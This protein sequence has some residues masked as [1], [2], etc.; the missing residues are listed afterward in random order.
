MSIVLGLTVSVDVALPTSL[1]L[2]MGTSR[3]RTRHHRETPGWPTVHRAPT[4][5][6]DAGGAEAAGVRRNAP[7]RCPPAEGPPRGLGPTVLLPGG[8]RQRGVVCGMVRR[9]EVRSGRA[10]GE[11][12][13]SAWAAVRAP[14]NTS[15]RPCDDTRG[16]TS[17]FAQRRRCGRSGWTGGKQPLRPDT[18]WLARRQN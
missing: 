8:A 17:G 2:L 7:P 12:A 4:S 5:V 6:A 14:P 18:V 13:S 16:G 10:A 3:G 11:P 1:L 15:R 9:T